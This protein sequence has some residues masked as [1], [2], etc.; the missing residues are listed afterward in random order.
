MLD[1]KFMIA[2]GIIAI[3]GISLLYVVV[4]G[5]KIQ[6]YSND[7]KIQAQTETVQ[8]ILK[9]VEQQG[10]VAIGDG[11]SSVVLV[12]YQPPEQGATGA[13]NIQTEQLAQG[14]ES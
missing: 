6:E 4:I 3:L 2:I 10:Y 7:K 1:K 9:I 14:Q 8:A 13:D 11:E 5:P 12:R